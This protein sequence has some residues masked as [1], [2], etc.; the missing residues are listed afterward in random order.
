MYLVRRKHP[1]EVIINSGAATSIITKAM[2]D[3]LGYPITASSNLV[4][5]TANGNR[6]RPLGEVQGL[7]INIR[8]SVIKTNLQVLESRD[9][10][11][12]LGNDWLRLRDANV[13]WKDSK[14]TINHK[15][16]TI[17]I[18]ITYTRTNQNQESSEEEEYSDEYEE[19]ELSEANVYYFSS[20]ISSS[21]FSEEELE[22]NPWVEH[23]TSSILKDDNPIAIKDY[24]DSPDFS[25]LSKSLAYMEIYQVQKEKSDLHLGP[26]TYEQQN[27]FDKVLE[28]YA[29]ICATSQTDIGRTNLITHRIHTG[30]AMPLSQSPYRCNLKNREF[31]RNEVT[32]IH[33]YLDYIYK[34]FEIKA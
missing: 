26:L 22:Y 17:V 13:S 25:E 34:D 28:D 23:T 30:D 33:D 15:G 29:D 12:I 8:H 9:K 3:S 24:D 2:L 18:P 27:Q 1:V 31:L 19:E 16:R 4:I 21:E 14:L 6:V 20:E 5:V 10:V 32:K 7:P 11:L